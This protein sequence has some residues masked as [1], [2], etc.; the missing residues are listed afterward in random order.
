MLKFNEFGQSKEILASLLEANIQEPR[1]GEG[2]MVVLK[3]DKISAF[4]AKVDG[5]VANKEF[6]FVK[7]PLST[8][9]N[10]QVM[11]DGK[12]IVTLDVYANIDDAQSKSKKVRTITWTSNP[13]SYYNH[14]KPTDGITW[15]RDTPTL[16]TV[17]CIGVFFKGID[18]VISEIGAGN[19]HK[20]RPRF[21]KDVLQILSSGEDWNSK[22][23]STIIEKIQTDLKVAPHQNPTVLAVKVMGVSCFQTFLKH[24]NI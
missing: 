2:S 13:D 23:K 3:T 5:F 6:V 24:R 12:P 7:A 21:E 9:T 15:G 1:Y 16:E 19:L 8:A 22:G 20:I 18:N 17:Q 14:L 10:I 4:N 11:G